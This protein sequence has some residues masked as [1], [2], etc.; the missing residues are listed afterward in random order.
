MSILLKQRIQEEMKTAMRQREQARLDVI[1]LI[2]A[3]V[4]QIE[5]DERVEVDDA[6]LLLVLDKLQKQTQD[7]LVQFEQAGRAE[8]A[9]KARFELSLIKSYLPEPLTESA[10]RTLVAEAIASTGAKSVREMAQVMAVLKP[11][12]QGRVDMGL[13][14]QLV[15]ERLA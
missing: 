2:L 12:V 13:V 4:K 10:V 14:G 11:Q 3:A 6:R 1:R 7:S 8:L 9:D 15:K 5:V